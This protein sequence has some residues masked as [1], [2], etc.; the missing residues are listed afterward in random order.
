MDETTARQGRARDWFEAL[1][2]KLI[3][4]MEALEAECPQG[5]PGLAPGRFALE[6]WSRLSSRARGSRAP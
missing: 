1:Q 3:A 5:A 6:P 4:A 2:L